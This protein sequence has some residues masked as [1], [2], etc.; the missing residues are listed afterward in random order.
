MFVLVYNNVSKNKQQ[1]LVVAHAQTKAG[2]RGEMEGL[3][4][5]TERETNNN[6]FLTFARQ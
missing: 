3:E 6:I 5:E 2:K 1:K 4:R